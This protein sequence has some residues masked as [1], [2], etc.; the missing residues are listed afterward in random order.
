MQVP[1]HPSLIGNTTVL[2]D[3]AE[4]PILELTIIPGVSSKRE[5][6]KFNWTYS[7]YTP[8]ILSLQLV[9]ENPLYISSHPL[10]PDSIQV[11]IHGFQYFADTRANFSP[12]V[13]PQVNSQLKI[14]AAQAQASSLLLILKIGVITI[15]IISVAMQMSLYPFLQTVRYLQLIS[16]IFLIPIAFPATT[17]I[18]FSA[19]MQ[20]A[21]W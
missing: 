16:H 21:N 17:T 13:L 2:I 9:F 18:F 14:D 15:I 10:N 19:L 5:L 3:G 6:L 8:S 20:I 12:E 7:N 4:W 11:Q 1:S